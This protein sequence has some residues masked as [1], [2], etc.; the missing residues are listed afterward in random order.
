MKASLTTG[1][2]GN[3]T[4]AVDAACAMD[5]MDEGSRVYATKA[6]LAAKVRKASQ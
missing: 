4:T 5:F 6:L 2:F 1:E 3:A